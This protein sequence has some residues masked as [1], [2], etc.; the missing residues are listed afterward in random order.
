MRTMPSWQIFGDGDDRSYLVFGDD[1][2]ELRMISLASGKHFLA[3][4]PA[5]DELRW[6]T[7]LFGLL[8]GAHLVELYDAFEDIDGDG[9][10]DVPGKKGSGA[11]VWLSGRTGEFLTEVGNGSTFPI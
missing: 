9:W 4:R 10:L 6:D 8:G 1:R 2:S 11:G 3:W 7:S 5:T